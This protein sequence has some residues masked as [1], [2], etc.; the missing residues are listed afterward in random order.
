MLT[1]A[2]S[3]FALSFGQ[4]PES[5]HA[6]AL[7]EHRH[8]VPFRAPP[9]LRLGGRGSLGTPRVD[10]VVYGYYPYWVTEWENI[11]WDLLTHIAFFALEMRADGTISARHGW[12]D[13]GFVST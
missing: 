13:A 5:A 12:P 4:V 1:A 3:L 8:D 6:R 2:L 7:F 10:R 9:S 11:R